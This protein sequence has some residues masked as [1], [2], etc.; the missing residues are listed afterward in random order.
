VRADHVGAL[1]ERLCTLADR[2][3]AG[4]SP[5]PLVAPEALLPLDR[6]D[7][8]F[9]QQL[10]Q[11]EPF[12]IGHPRPLFWTPGCRV[13]QRRIMGGGH[14]ALEIET[15]SGPLRAIA[16]RWNRQA[17]LA[18]LL[19]LAFHLVLDSWQGR[20]RLQLELVA[21]RPAAEGRVLLQRGRRLY[22]CRREGQTVTI[23]NPEGQ[24][25][26]H[27][28]GGDSPLPQHPA[29]AALVQQAAHALGLVA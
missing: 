22:D 6:I 10:Q 8:A 5:A 14:L 28:C 3:L 29:T 21:L 7:R 23:R 20:E 12:G 16:W 25:L 1:H 18:P 26:H 15:S 9:H 13:L 19:D 17:P 24:E 11:L 2:W 27:V 4:R